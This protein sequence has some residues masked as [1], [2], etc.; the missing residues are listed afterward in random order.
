MSDP[1][2]AF[3]P[4]LILPV[5]TQIVTRAAVKAADGS[6]LYPRGS[7][8]VIIEALPD[9]LHHYRV[10]FPAGGEHVFSRQEFAVRKHL[11]ETAL[12]NQRSN[13]FAELSPCVIYRC[14]V[15]S[16]AY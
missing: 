1:R 11:R 2:E 16:R 4:L 15:G 8:A 7:V 6:V 12:Q 13:V 5:G 10:R 14:V 9:Q 3:E